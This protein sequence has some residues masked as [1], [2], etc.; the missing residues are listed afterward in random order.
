M[1]AFPVAARA[2][3]TRP[4]TGSTWLESGDAKFGTWLE[5]TEDGTEHVIEV[6]PICQ[7]RLCPLASDMTDAAAWTS[8][9]PLHARDQC[10]LPCVTNVRFRLAPPRS[11]CDATVPSM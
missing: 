3:A 1:A 9:H 8:R 5:W 6:T 4:C 11:H 7:K 10:T 2:G